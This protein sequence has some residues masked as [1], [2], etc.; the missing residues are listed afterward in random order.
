MAN[1]QRKDLDFDEWE[2]YGRSY[3]RRQR[4]EAK[5]SRNRYD[6]EAIRNSSGRYGRG[7]KLSR[8]E[9]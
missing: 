5:G 2:E 7:G 6:K 1:R 4:V 3:N 8:E 9:W